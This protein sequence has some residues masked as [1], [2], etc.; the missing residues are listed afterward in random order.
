MWTGVLVA[1]MIVAAI[2]GQGA[3][4]LLIDHH[5]RG[6]TNWLPGG[7]TGALVADLALLAA[8][9]TFAAIADAHRPKTEPK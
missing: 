6:L 7:F 4:R 2:G 8:G 1:A 9:L 3:I 5:D